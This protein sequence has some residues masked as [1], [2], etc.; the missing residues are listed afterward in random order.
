[1][2][3]VKDQEPFEGPPFD[4]HG[5]TKTQFDVYLAAWRAIALGTLFVVYDDQA[6][7]VYSDFIHNLAEG[8][9]FVTGGHEPR[10]VFPLDSFSF[11]R[12]LR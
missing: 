3:E 8:D 1:M 7:L 10:I 5:L 12:E 11:R 6:G 4:G 2:V 9:T